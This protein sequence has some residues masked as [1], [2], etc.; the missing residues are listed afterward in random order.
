[1]EETGVDETLEG[2]G[3]VIETACNPP[4]RHV[5]ARIRPK[6]K[7]RRNP[8]RTGCP[9]DWGALAPALVGSVVLLAVIVAG[10]VIAMDERWVAMVLC[11]VAA[12]GFGIQAWRGR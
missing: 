1:M 7:R 12:V 4:F 3:I 6:P 5:P 9:V 8:P 2:T 10:L 11:A